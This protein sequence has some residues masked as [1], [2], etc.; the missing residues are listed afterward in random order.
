M[1]AT[2]RLRKNGLL[3][4]T[5]KPTLGSSM[6]NSQTTFP[7]AAALKLN[8]GA[9]NLPTFGDP[10]YVVAIVDPDT[11][12]E[13]IM[14]VTAQTAGN[15]TPTVLRGQ[16]STTAIAHSSG[17]KIVFGP[18]A[19]DSGGVIGSTEYAPGS[20]TVINNS[21]TVADVDATNLI[22]SF[23]APASGAVRVTLNGMAAS[24]EQWALRE[25][26][27]TI[28]GPRTVNN[29]NNADRFTAYFIVTGL[30]PGS[31]HT[32]KWAH[33]NVNGTSGDFRYGPDG[34]THLYGPA[35]MEVTAVTN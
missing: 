33:C 34:Q 8:D 10:Q 11:A 30:T 32:Y 12:T 31:T 2:Q 1:A 16:E 14:W 26:S 25:A 17:A 23:T 20:D 13:E 35:V 4:G 7:L 21:G 18:T 22:V 27:S 6:D 28:A 15:A 9:T 29:G 3:C 5:A 19:W 24:S